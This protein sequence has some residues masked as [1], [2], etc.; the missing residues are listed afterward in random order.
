MVQARLRAWE[1]LFERALG[2]LDAAAAHGMP[3]E[4]WSFGG[5]TVLMRRYRHR[6]SKDIDIFLPDP[7]LLG[8]VSP[9][10]NPA[11]EALTTDYVEQAGFVK[12]YFPEGEIDFVAS[13]FLTPDPVR[14]EPIAGRAVRVETSAEIIAKKLWHRGA[15]LTARDLFDFALVATREPEAL[16]LLRD[17][18]AAQRRLLLERLESREE[19]LRTVFSQLQTLEFQ[20]SFDDCVKALR[21]ALEKAATPRAEQERARYRLSPGLAGVQAAA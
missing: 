10:L 21:E 1:T 16:H 20:P 5:G 6:V 7:Q 12:L 4:T 8:Y 9:R 18:L 15:E 2:I 19:M 14:V 3:R 13:G 11:A 17:I